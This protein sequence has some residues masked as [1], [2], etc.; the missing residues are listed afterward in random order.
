MLGRLEKYA[1]V[2]VVYAVGQFVE[3]LSRKDTISFP[4]QVTAIFH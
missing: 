1:S 4:N 2:I 3:T